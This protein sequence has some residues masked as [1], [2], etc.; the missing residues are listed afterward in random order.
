LHKKSKKKYKKKIPHREQW[1]S[2]LR[3]SSS[4]KTWRD[5]LA[6]IIPTKKVGHNRVTRITKA[7][8]ISKRKSMKYINSQQPHKL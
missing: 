6:R 5:L 8:H 1:W 4:T 7:Q 3:Y 2:F